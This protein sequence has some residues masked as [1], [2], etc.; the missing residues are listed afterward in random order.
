MNTQNILEQK[1]IESNRATSIVYK[2]LDLE[3]RKLYNVQNH[4]IHLLLSYHIGDANETALL[5]D[6]ESNTYKIKK[7]N[8]IDKLFEDMTSELKKLASIY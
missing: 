2:E 5:K 6:A 3:V 1:G 7:Y 4:P 8:S